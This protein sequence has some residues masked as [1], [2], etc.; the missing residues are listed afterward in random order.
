MV[1]YSV[2]QHPKYKYRL[3]VA[4]DHTLSNWSRRIATEIDSGWAKLSG[5]GVLSIAEGYC[6][7]GPSG[8]A[9]D[10]MSFARGSLVH[11][12]LYQL[13]AEC[14]IPKHPWKAHADRELYDICREDGMGWLRAQWVYIAVKFF[15]GAR[16]RYS[17]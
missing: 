11:D 8:P 1:A 16:D 12:V 3:D 7:D 5:D 14:K 15:G 6:W 9:M 2:I 4:H 10:S 13:I 17:P